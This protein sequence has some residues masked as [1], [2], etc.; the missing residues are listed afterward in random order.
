[1]KLSG[2]KVAVL[3]AD[4]YEKSE[5]EKPVE[6]L[7]NEGAD[8]KIISLK[9]GEIKSMDGHEW[10]TPVK[11]DLT[12]ADAS[13]ENF[14]ALVLPGGVLNPDALR[15][16]ENAVRF[17]KDFFAQNKVVAAICHGGQTLID[18]EVLEGRK[19]TSYPAVRKD[20]MNA[21]ATWEDKE[22][23]I[24]G[25]LITSRTPDDIPAFNEAIIT[26]LAK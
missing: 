26:A 4:G 15:T 5:L 18:A 14:D 22:V 6:A 13:A 21:G 3:A 19:L 11:V 2:K 10:S 7:R 12:V 23:V 16:D 1:M 24:D 9:S 25:N 17:T 20:L 8:V